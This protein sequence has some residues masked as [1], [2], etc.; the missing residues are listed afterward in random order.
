M[1]FDETVLDPILAHGLFSAGLDFK[2]QAITFAAEVQVAPIHAIILVGQGLC[3]GFE[4]QRKFCVV[5]NGQRFELNLNAAKL[6]DRILDYFPRNCQ[7]GFCPKGRNSFC[8]FGVTLF[9]VSYLHQSGPVA[10][11]QELH[12]LLIAQ[13]LQPTL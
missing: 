1:D 3:K 13:G 4:G 8:Q 12:A 6:N 2:D 11:D 10:Q 7:R 9:P 5:F